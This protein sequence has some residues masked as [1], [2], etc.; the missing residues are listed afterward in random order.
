METEGAFDPPYPHG[1]KMVATLQPRDS[2]YSCFLDSDI[3]FLRPNDPANLIHEG[4]V[5]LTPAASMGWAGQEV[6][7][8]IY[9]TAGLPIP[10]ER[11]RLMNQ[12]K[13]KDRMP[14]F[15]NNTAMPKACASPR[16]G[17]RLPPRSRQ[18]PRFRPSGPISTR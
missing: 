13:G 4:H 16:F 1:N 10:E 15:P 2:E 8:L 12:N 11:I 18:N 7:T 6:W 17:C 9:D 3:L 14:S 5:S